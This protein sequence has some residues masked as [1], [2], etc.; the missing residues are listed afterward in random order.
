VRS[1]THSVKSSKTPSDDGCLA[2]IGNLTVD[3]ISDIW[4][5]D[6]ISDIWPVD[7][8]SDIWRDVTVLN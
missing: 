7:I 1:Q 8:I 6:I 3:I 2:M 4:P 5:V